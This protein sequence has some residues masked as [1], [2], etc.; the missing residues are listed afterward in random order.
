MKL[1]EGKKGL[2]LGV[3]NQRS[4]A[5]GIAQAASE[6]GA[7]L[8]FTY[9]GDVSK[10][11]VEPLAKGIGSEILLDC[12]VSNPEDVDKVFAEIE[13]KW[14]KLDFLVH[15]IANSDKDELRGRFVDV[16]ANNFKNAMNISCY[17]LI[18]LCKKAEP[19][20]EKAGGG[21][22]ITMTYYG[23]EKVVPH[24]NVMGV[25]K[26]ALEAS[27]KYLAADMGSKNI[28]VNAISSGPVKTLA[29]AGIGGFSYIFKWNEYNSPLRRNVTLEDNGK[30]AVYLL[31]DMSSGVTGEV[32]HVD[33]G[34]HVV[35]MKNLDAPDLTV[36]TEVR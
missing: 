23:A 16:S 11:R 2:I 15:S 13:K 34:Y 29:A 31:S 26:A 8:A 28:R 5:W 32:V 25:A 12:D 20:M 24:Y 1:L 36:P 19:L 30:T 3:L 14:G 21:S 33:A 4:I 22:V 18:A 7:E 9:F 27:V 6:A 10:K 35:G 17:S